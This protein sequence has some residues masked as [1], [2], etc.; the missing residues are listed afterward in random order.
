VRPEDLPVPAADRPDLAE[1]EAAAE[2]LRPI[3]AAT[4]LLPLQGDGDDPRVLLKPET[5]QP[6]GSFKLRGVY[7]RVAG[8]DPDARAVGISTVSAGNTAQAL[9]WCGRHFGVPARSLMPEGAP[10]SK[11]EKV[12]AYGGTPVL[13][14]REE[15]FRFMREHLWEDEPYAFV[16]PWTDRDVMVGH[17]SMGLELLAECPGVET[18]YLPVGG[19]GLL[20]GVGSA[21][22]A[23]GSDVRIVAVEPASCPALHASLAT[24]RPAEVACQTICDGVAVPYITAEMFPLLS[25]LVDDVVLVTEEEVQTAIRRLALRDHLVVE[26]AGALAAAA[27]LKTPE[28]E[29]G[30]SVCPLTGGSIDAEKLAAI[31]AAT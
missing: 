5:F 19:G 4:P 11:I 14:P 7:H 1:F 29:R 9:A 12:R 23:A 13:A 25:E 21:L 6:V 18:V 24:G 3:L 27:A 8:M 15:V 30:L 17:G 2:G 26:G 10:V 22:R 31:L 16:H 28:S 20:G